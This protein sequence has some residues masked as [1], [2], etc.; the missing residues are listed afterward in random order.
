VFTTQMTESLDPL[1]TATTL[2]SS[3]DPERS[4]APIVSRYRSRE[5]E[6][7]FVQKIA[8]NML[9]HKEDTSSHSH[10]WDLDGT[11]LDGMCNS[12]CGFF[13]SAEDATQSW[14]LLYHSLR[15]LLQM[16]ELL[17]CRYIGGCLRT[18]RA[19]R[20]SD[21]ECTDGPVHAVRLR[22]EVSAWT[23]QGTPVTRLMNKR[24]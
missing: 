5:G 11:Y 4:N 23:R 6:H 14:R 9:R 10:I 7:T 18:A 13:S 17:D 3:I 8:R 1:V 15:W 19:G 21:A 16:L 12:R 2:K 22:R 20:I 24:I